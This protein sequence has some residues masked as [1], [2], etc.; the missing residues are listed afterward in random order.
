MIA[1]IFILSFFA[2]SASASWTGNMWS[3]QY[4][5]A[6]RGADLRDLDYMQGNPGM[7]EFAIPE[8]EWNGLTVT[9]W[10]RFRMSNTNDYSGRSAN[11]TTSAFWCPERVVR[12]APDL[13]GG[14]FGYPNG[15]NLSVSSS[16]AFDFEREAGFAPSN[17][18]V[19]GAYTLAGWAS[20]AVTVTLGGK[21]ISVGP[22]EFNLNAE[23]GE[24]DG[25]I[26]T[27]SGPVAVAVSRL[28]AHQFFSMIDGVMGE[29]G[30]TDET[31]VTNEILFISFRIRLDASNHVY[32][33]DMIHLGWGD[34][35]GQTKTNALPDD[36]AVR[37]MSSGGL[38]R[39]GLCGLASP[40]NTWS[41]DVFDA[42]VQTKWLSDS[43]IERIYSNGAQ[44]IGRRPVPQWR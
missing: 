6:R 42:R 11:L 40:T 39:F 5:D 13:T 10:M 36:P 20:N 3:P 25:I 33:A 26:V 27:G 43:D 37:S 14:A 31:C 28:H 23:P 12:D 16:I 35:S 7:V 19:R 15:T 22:G 4:G 29:R 30:I 17:V 18:F 44:E 34:P 38:Y 21:D 2:F 9:M 8:G 41:L 1:R 24:S 32:R